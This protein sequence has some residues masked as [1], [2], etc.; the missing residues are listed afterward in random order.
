MSG[1][2]RYSR[3][4][5]GEQ[6]AALSDHTSCSRLLLLRAREVQTVV[7]LPL[8]V[9]DGLLLLHLTH[10]LL[11]CLVRLR[12]ESEPMSS[13]NV[14]VH[15]R[16]GYRTLYETQR[17]VVACCMMT[18]ES[19]YLMIGVPITSRSLSS[20]TIFWSSFSCLSQNVEVSMVASFLQNAAAL[21]V[22]DYRRDIRRDP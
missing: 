10:A 15:S 2:D 21:I 8:F 12:H 7:H 6:T 17:Q 13:A 9:K 16:E 4:E 1:A 18:V 5:L 20:R 14:L 3:D 22:G 19:P 11:L